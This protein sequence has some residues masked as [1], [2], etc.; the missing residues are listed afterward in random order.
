MQFPG[1]PRELQLLLDDVHQQL[2][3]YLSDPRQ[4]SIF[5]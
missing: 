2:L 5:E 3:A 1:F 4:A